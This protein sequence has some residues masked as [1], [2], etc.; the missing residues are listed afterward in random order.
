MA[1]SHVNSI[2]SE[3][4]T[5]ADPTKLIS[6]GAV[7][8][9][10]SKLGD[11]HSAL[12]GMVMHSVVYFNLVKQDLIVYVKNSSGDVDIPTYLGKVVVVD[13]GMPVIAGTTAGF[14]YLTV[15]FGAG[16]IGYAEGTP[17]VPTETDRDS[18]LG[19]DVLF[20]RK[21]FV[22][23]PRGVKWQGTIAGVTPSDAELAAN[24]AWSKVYEDKQI[25]FVGLL[26]N[27]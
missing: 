19:E 6:S 15:L 21:H 16:A 22:I 3:N 20:S 7:I 5:T 23:H 4:Y 27:G 2:A 8:E 12:T 13:D 11:A 14:K 26:T 9:T 24:T 1:A 17:E 25:R 18:A 10:I